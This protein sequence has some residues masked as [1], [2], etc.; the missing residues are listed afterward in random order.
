MKLFVHSLLLPA[1]LWTAGLAG[2]P[3]K[4]S[5]DRSKVTPNMTEGVVQEGS[6]IFNYVDTVDGF[7]KKQFAGSERDEY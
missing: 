3:E 1:I 4:A 6:I 7:L 2:E 5:P